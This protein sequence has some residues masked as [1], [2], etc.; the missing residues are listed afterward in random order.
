[1][2]LTEAHDASG[3]DSGE[4]VLD[5]WLRKR[6]FSNQQMAASRTYVVCPTGTLTV[7]GFFALSMGQILAQEVT[8]SMRRNMPKFIPAVVLGRL[9][10]SRDWQGRGLG[11]ALLTDVVARAQLASAEVSA[12]LVIVHAI[13]PAAEAFYLR[14]GFTRLPG[15]RPTFALDLVKLMR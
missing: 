9:A 14:H 11:R 2:L 10:I 15:D 5:D 12:R 1:M 6:A 8:G 13:S 7:I 3:F 4:A